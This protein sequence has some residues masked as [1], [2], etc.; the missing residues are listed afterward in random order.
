MLIG[1]MRRL[2]PLCLFV[3]GLW[4]ASG[5]FAAAH[6]NIIELTTRPASGNTIYWNQIGVPGTTFDTT[7]NFVST[8]GTTGIAG[9]SS[10]TTGAIVEQCCIGL[11]GL[12]DGNF[13][14][15]DFVLSAA[16]KSN[17][18]TTATSL[19][20][21]FNARLQVVGAQIARNTYGDFIAEIQAFDGGTLLGTF[22]ENGTETSSA[23]GSAIFLGVSDATADVTSVVFTMACGSDSSASC[24]NFGINQATIDGAEPLPVPEPAP[25]LLIASGLLALGFARR[26]AS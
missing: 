6:A 7:Q 24:S 25:F 17:P 9:L 3:A 14:P 5:I 11:S 1:E 26:R 12:W 2:K 13:S 10:D 16:S 21:T 8:L 18:V 22:T 15:G 20:L 19:T 4:L 23:N